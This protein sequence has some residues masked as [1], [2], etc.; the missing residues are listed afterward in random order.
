MNF[1]KKIVLF[2]F[3]YLPT[4]TQAQGLSVDI[5]AALSIGSGE[6][7]DNQSAT[8]ID[9]QLLNINYKFTQKL[10]LTVGYAFSTLDHESY[11]TSLTTQLQRIHLGPSITIMLG[12]LSWELIPQIIIS[13]KAVDPASHEQSGFIFRKRTNSLV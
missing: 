7:Y 5:G 6:F 10:G 9:Y 4:L 11:N 12:Y 3:L 2:V 8:G 1:F 13:G